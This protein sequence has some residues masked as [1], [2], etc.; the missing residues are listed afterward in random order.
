ML[1]CPSEFASGYGET[2]GARARTRS[3]AA[4]A[5]SVIRDRGLAG[6]NKLQGMVERYRLFKLFERRFTE[7]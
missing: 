2:A 3:V 6:L 5:L 4:D 7:E 1:I